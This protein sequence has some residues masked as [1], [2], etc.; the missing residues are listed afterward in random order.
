MEHDWEM[1]P[2]PLA[3]EMEGGLEAHGEGT[4]K[5]RLIIW[6]RHG[7]TSGS[8]WGKDVEEKNEYEKQVN[9][10]AGDGK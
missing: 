2:Q 5:Q 8:T 3:K 10:M 7:R 4:W 9:G 6:G 1:K